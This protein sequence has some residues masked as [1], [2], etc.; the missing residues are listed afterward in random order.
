MNRSW[1][2]RFSLLVFFIVVAVVH[3]YPTVAN[4]DL[5]HTSFPFKKKVNLG[6]DLQGGL[7]MVYGVDFKKVYSE[8]ASRAVDSIVSQLDKENV[9]ATKGK[10]DGTIEDNPTVNL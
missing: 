1:W 6:L 10:V 9:K 4:L 8:T 7:Y 3:V 2:L 5:E